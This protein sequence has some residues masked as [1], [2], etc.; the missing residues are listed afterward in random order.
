MYLAN[1]ISVISSKE[2]SLPGMYERT[3]I[4]SRFVPVR[5][6]ST[7]GQCERGLRHVCNV[8]LTI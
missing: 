3:R 5:P 7:P 4:S 1:D 6:G 2:F 8:L